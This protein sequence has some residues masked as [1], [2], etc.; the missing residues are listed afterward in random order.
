M[1][2]V[3]LAVASGAE[4]FQKPV[5]IKR[6]LPHMASDMKIARMFLSEARLAMHLSHQNLVQVLDLGRGPEGLYFMMELV[7]GW[8]LGEI[9]GH[10]KARLPRFPDS[11]VGFVGA[12]VAAG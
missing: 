4:G 10:A 11:L 1:A 12:Q 2:E 3:F 5:A 6:L 9:F 7:N 8:D